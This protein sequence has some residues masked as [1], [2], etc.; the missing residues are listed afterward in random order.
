MPTIRT[1]NK[2]RR[3]KTDRKALNLLSDPKFRTEI[4]RN[5]ILQAVQHFAVE[6][7]FLNSPKEEWPD[8]VIAD[9][10]EAEVIGDS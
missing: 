4:Y 2:R 9:I 7:T 1:C 8:E 5:A 3:R 6:W 10:L